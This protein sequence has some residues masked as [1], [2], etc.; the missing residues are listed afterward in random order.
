MAR[1]MQPSRRMPQREKKGKPDQR[2]TYAAGR[3]ADR[4][5][6]TKSNDRIERTFNSVGID[7][8]VVRIPAVL[9]DP[10]SHFICKTFH[11]HNPLTEI[12]HITILYF[13]A[14]SFADALLSLPKNNTIPFNAVYVLYVDDN[15]AMALNELRR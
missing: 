13:A 14:I 15:R 10:S 4:Q 12:L 6:D 2:D 9:R 3:S 5:N 8:L 11:M 7:F 1:R